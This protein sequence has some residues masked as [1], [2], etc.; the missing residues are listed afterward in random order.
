[1][2]WFRKF[3]LPFFD[4]IECH[5]PGTSFRLMKDFLVEKSVENMELCLAVCKESNQGRASLIADRADVMEIALACV[6]A[7]DRYA[8]L[9][10]LMPNKLYNEAV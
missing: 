10:T 8:S 5:H 4:R 3:A 6:Y 7:C 1:M 2:S 9:S